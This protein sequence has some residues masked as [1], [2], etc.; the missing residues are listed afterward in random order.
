MARAGVLQRP[1][2][3]AVGLLRT[4]YAHT[5][6]VSGGAVYTMPEGIITNH[7]VFRGSYQVQV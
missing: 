2:Q 7:L 5:A 6:T 4:A 1:E 3:A